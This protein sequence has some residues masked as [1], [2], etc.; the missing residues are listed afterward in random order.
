MLLR[1]LVTP[2]GL[3]EINLLLM[4]EGARHV[5][6][7][8]LLRR[9]RERAKLPSDAALQALLDEI[10]EANRAEARRAWS[11]W[12]ALVT[13]R[14]PFFDANHRT[15]LLAF[16]RATAAVWGFEYRLAHRRLGADDAREPKARQASPS[17]IRGDAE[18]RQHR[19][20]ARPKP[21][22]EDL[23]RGLRWKA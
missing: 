16:N 18:A 8:E 5:G 7:V 10:P 6:G 19:G 22:G 11:H 21:P 14:Q 1:D 4:L 17:A 2:H 23:L 9:T 15:A 3:K 12:M 13:L 20:L